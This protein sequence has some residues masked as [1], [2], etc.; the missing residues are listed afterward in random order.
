MPENKVTFGLDKVHIAFYDAD[1]LT[2]P[3]WEAPTPMPGAVRWTPEAQGETSTFYADNG[4]YFVVSAN[5]GYTGEL[6]MALIPD[7]ILARMLGWEIDNNGMLVEVTNG[8]P[9]KFALLGQIQGD[10]KNRRFVY[11]DCQASR[12]AKERT[13]KGESVEVATD[14]LNLTISPIE[15][16]GKTVVKGDI[17]LSA[18]NAT[19][20]NGFFTNVLTPTFGG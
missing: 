5:N 2:P 12:P 19:A 13:T 9:E 3:T 20:Y 16:D 15:L 17:E 14:V 8:I 6:E 1:S 11:Y 18:T 10:Q 4:A 7:A